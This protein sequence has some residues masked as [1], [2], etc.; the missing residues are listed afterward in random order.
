MVQAGLDQETQQRR[1]ARRLAASLCLH[2]ATAATHLTRLQA[3][4]AEHAPD[5]CL[6]G[7]S[8]RTVARAAGWRG[9]PA[10]FWEAMV[11]AG[12]LTSRPSGTQL[13]EGIAGLEQYAPR[14]HWQGGVRQPASGAG[15]PTTPRL[16]VHGL[17]QAALRELAG[18]V[19][20]ANFAAFLA[21][22]VALYQSDAWV[23]IGAPSAYVCETLAQRFRTTMNRALFDVSGLPLRA[24]I[25]C[26]PPQAP[27]LA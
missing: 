25:V 19:N 14:H 4:A 8:P 12:C 17:W 21:D 3:W 16:H 15:L 24:R 26:L 18:T 23:T 1:L 27:D 6:T 7:C 2:P 20:H 5:G 22:T 10:M 13:Q 11:Q 9:D